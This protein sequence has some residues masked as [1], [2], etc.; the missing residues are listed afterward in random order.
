MHA[1][2]RRLSL[3][4]LLALSGPL[5]EPCAQTVPPPPTLVDAGARGHLQAGLTA[6]RNQDLKKA[7]KELEASYRREQSPALLE[8]LG[9][10][11]QRE[12]QEVTAGDLYRRF[13]EEAPEAAASRQDLV[14][15]IAAAQRQAAEVAISG[16]PGAFV[17]VDGRLVGRLPLSRAL[18][19]QPGK[20]RVSHEAGGRSVS[21]NLDL[22]SGVP[23]SLRFVPDSAHIAV[24]TRP[25]IVV[26][27]INGSFRAADAD[28]PLARAA[29]AGLRHSGQA[30]D[31]SAERVS[32]LNKR[33]CGADS[34]CLASVAQRLGAH[35]AVSVSTAAPIR[36]T[37]VDARL[38]AVTERAEVACSSCDAP[39][40]AD[41][42]QKSVRELVGRAV[43]HAYGTLDAR[44]LPAGAELSVA[45]SPVA[46]AG[47]PLP[48]VEPP[49][50]FKTPARIPV[51]S[52][53]LSITLRKRDYL[54]AR[55]TVEVAPDEVRALDVTLQPNL[56][57]QRRRHVAIGKWCL[58]GA[59]LLGVIGGV[60]GIGLDGQFEQLRPSADD[61]SQEVPH[62]FNSQIQGSIILGL[63]IAALGGAIGLGIY[64]RRMAKQ[65]AAAEEAALSPPGSTESATH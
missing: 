27:S 3:L 11:A 37:Y 1:R 60:I 62:V 10:L 23:V 48:G 17:S 12:R 38:G 16:E 52:G 39:R 59:G 40:L 41:A 26:V 58:M 8:L 29:W 5:P 31:L 61:P 47:G 44:V 36:I 7:Q 43:N 25:P 30:H 35:G 14:Q 22:A 15:L 51:L 56:L 21:Y 6:L 2:A 4:S 24:E 13:L 57:A 63:G 45:E 50:A 46:Q 65:A 53:R 64:E 49:R 32:E 18:L 55:S 54:P 28:L 34:S 42:L 20:H 19:V 9:Q 33:G